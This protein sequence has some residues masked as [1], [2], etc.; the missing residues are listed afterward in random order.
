[1]VSFIRLF[2]LDFL[3][4]LTKP[5]RNERLLKKSQEK[6]QREIDIME[7]IQEFRMLKA[8]LKEYLGPKVANSLVEPA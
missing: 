4:C 2:A 1:M 7:F 3:C 8:G 5:N 6:L